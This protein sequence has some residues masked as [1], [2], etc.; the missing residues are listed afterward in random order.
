[1]SSD[2]ETTRR[3][4]VF[5]T[6]VYPP[7]AAA[8]GQQIAD[9][10][11]DLVAR[12]NRV[13]VYTA[14]RGY[15]E[16]NV[17]YPSHE[18]RDGVIVRRLPF[19][20][21]GK[22][23]L[24]IRLVGGLFFLFQACLRALF[25]PG[26]SR[27]VFTTAPPLSPLAIA[28]FS[29]LRPLQMIY[30]VMDLNPDQLIEMGILAP[31]SVPARL[32]DWANRFIL[33]R[34]AAVIVC[35]DHMARR[36]SA[37]HDPGERLHV[38]TPWAQ[39][40]HLRSVPHADNPFRATHFQNGRRVVMYSGNH[41][42]TNPLDTLLDAVRRL[43]DEPRLQF[44]FVGGGIGKQRVDTMTSTDVVSLPYQPL[45]QLEYSLSAADVH[46]ATIGA[47]MVGIVHPCKVYGAM[48]VGRPLLTFGPEEC[49]L[50]DLSR[51]GIGWHV[52][53][54]D[55]SQAEQV[56]RSIAAMPA[57]Q[58]QEMGR[59]AQILLRDKF[60]SRMLRARVSDV[61]EGSPASLANGHPLPPLPDRS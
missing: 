58:L 48:A 42:L 25:M 61:I 12:G 9:A 31:T 11:S 10:A 53:Q 8:V 1:M 49:H 4:I 26:L 54:G 24:A 14:N 23:S 59:R 13:I 17:H 56:L 35:D 33:R 6:Q 45:A 47:G 21:F 43:S 46:V 41:A 28:C 44:A 60:D 16:P 55:V 32:L 15:D 29:I 39:E 40:D 20:S 38:V 2:T 34:A 7:D 51:A 57:E 36:I 18:I 5:I 27:V 3:T 50:A 30:W 37:K 52:P 22:G 19:S